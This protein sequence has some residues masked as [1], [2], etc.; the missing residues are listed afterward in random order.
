MILA[1]FIGGLKPHVLFLFS[2]IWLFL[3]FIF[4]LRGDQKTAEFLA[5]SFFVLNALAFVYNLFK[6]K[7][8][9]DRS[10]EK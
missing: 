6:M 9:G 10:K 8:T 7:D 5:T 2:L 3:S 4:L 1:V